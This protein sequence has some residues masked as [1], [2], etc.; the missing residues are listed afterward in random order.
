MW[1]FP[2]IGENGLYG[3]MIPRSYESVP[4]FLN[5]TQD[6]GNISLV[7]YSIMNKQ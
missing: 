2:K 1:T 3:L 4:R 7:H 6:Q 5:V